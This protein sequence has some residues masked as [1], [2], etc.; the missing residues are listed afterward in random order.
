MNI[1]GPLASDNWP[2]FSIGGIRDLR[3]DVLNS[4][5]VVRSDSARMGD[6]LADLAP[7]PR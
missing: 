1:V 4:A 6:L 2:W 3:R 5:A 7:L